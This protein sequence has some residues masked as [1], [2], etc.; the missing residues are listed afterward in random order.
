[1]AIQ[2]LQ[3]SGKR[4]FD[5]QGKGIAYMMQYMMHVNFLVHFFVRI[6]V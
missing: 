2:T 3:K 6:R 4:K 1:M 5:I